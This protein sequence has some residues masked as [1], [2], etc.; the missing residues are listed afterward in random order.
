MTEILCGRYGC[1]GDGK[2]TLNKH[3]DNTLDEEREIYEHD[4]TADEQPIDAA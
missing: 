3:S 2:H 1:P 4:I